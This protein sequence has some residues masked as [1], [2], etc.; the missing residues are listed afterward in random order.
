[1]IGRGAFFFLL[2]TELV[3]CASLRG[4]RQTLR[5][6]CSTPQC[7][8]YDQE[9]NLLG[10]APNLISVSRQRKT[11]LTFSHGQQESQLQFEG[12][13]RWLDSLGANGL[14]SYLGGPGVALL[15]VATDLVT[16]AAWDY[17]N[18]NTISLA[19]KKTTLPPPATI[20]I[21][22]PQAE[23]ELFSD[24]MGRQVQQSLKE[25]YADA[26]VLDYN[27]TLPHFQRHNYSH[28][29]PFDSELMIIKTI[30]KVPMTHFAESLI[31][32]NNQQVTATVTI[33]DAFRPD[34][35]ESLQ[36]SWPKSQIKNWNSL[37]E[38]YWATKLIELLPNSIGLTTSTFF[39][40]GSAFDV[41]ST[42]T[43]SYLYN[44]EYIY[45]S[46]LIA[47]RLGFTASNIRPDYEDR[48]QYIF[49]WAFD[50]HFFRSKYDVTRSKLIYSG[51][52]LI[53][54]LG[55]VGL[56]N[57]G[58]G[59]G[60]EIGVSGQFG[61]VYFN[62]IPTIGTY[63]TDYYGQSKNELIGNMENTINL[64]YLS[65]ITKQWYFRLNVGG[66]GS[67]HAPIS[68]II[69]KY[70]KVPVS[71]ANLSQSKVSFGVEYYLPELRN[72]I[73]NKSLDWIH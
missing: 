65:E 16:G 13:Y 40:S 33:N 30:E 23:S 55:T 73:K 37:S 34:K 28:E 59:I 20:A 45:N 36:L 50:T 11:T 10:K 25:K 39:G 5:L 7:D 70:A 38:S 66:S 52:S 68:H 1:M 26:Q 64:G 44:L 58:L 63:Y 15:A 43:P 24:L 69:E 53:E 17:E 21:A 4:T 8:V 12:H 19:D 46:D 27:S 57:F 51:A 48:F 42:A 60:P 41:T 14:L 54:N 62:V 32:T 3:S 49:R 29:H 56:Y 67:N 47:G 6:A 9:K 31:S 61:Y 71:N 35:K 22:P 72:T 2:L 18:P